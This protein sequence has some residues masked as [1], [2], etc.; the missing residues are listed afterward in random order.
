MAQ[1]CLTKPGLRWPP[2]KI[3]PF[4]LCVS[5]LGGSVQFLW[6]CKE[7]VWVSM[8][9]EERGKEWDSYGSHAFAITKHGR[10][11]WP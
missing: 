5:C 6:S 4:P 9:L 1:K 7:H 3:K 8:L 11:D 2:H 10:M